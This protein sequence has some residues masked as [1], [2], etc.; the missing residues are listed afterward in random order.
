MPSNSRPFV[1]RPVSTT[2]RSSPDGG[3]DE[4]MAARAPRA[5]SASSGQDAS[6]ALT[7]DRRAAGTTTPTVPAT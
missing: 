2:T 7:S 3:T 5:S 6:Q 1:S 4:S